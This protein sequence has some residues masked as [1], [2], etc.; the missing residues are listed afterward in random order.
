MINKIKLLLVSSLVILTIAV[1]GCDFLPTTTVTQQSTITATTKTTTVTSYTGNSSSG[2]LDFSSVVEK[3]RPSVVQIETSEAAG[4]GWV[5]DSSGIIVTNAHVIEDVYSADEINVITSDGTTY[6]ATS[7]NSDTSSDLAIIRINAS[8]LT[9]ASVGSSDALKVGQPVA[10]IG[11]ALSLGISM[12]GGWVSRL[13][14]SVTDDSGTTYVDLI[15]TDTAINFGNSG[16]PLVNINGEVVG[17]TSIKLVEEG[18]EGVGYAISIDYAM[19]II[20]QLIDN[21]YVT[22]GYLGVTIRTV[23]AT[24][25][26]ENVLAVDTGAIVMD[27]VAG[28]PAD[29]AGLEP[30]DVIV[31]VDGEKITNNSQLVRYIQARAP[32]AQ[33]ELSVYRGTQKLTITVTLGSTPATVS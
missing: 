3:V 17:I 4:T 13:N 16:G 9:A 5:I 2:Y 29:E 33:V 12:T 32:G 24:I 14:A 11:N 30:Y 23:N 10:A 22:R 7:F 21:G 1:S 31:A 6:T 25:G 19:P 27:V 8:G 15:A 28:S 20:Q 26:A 18:V